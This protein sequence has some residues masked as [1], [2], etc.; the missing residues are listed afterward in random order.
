LNLDAIVEG[1][2]GGKTR[3]ISAAISL[4]EDGDPQAFELLKRLFPHGGRSHVVGI[5]GPPGAG[6]STLTDR[7]IGL[8]RA[9]GTR[10]GIVAVDPTSPYSGGAIL[11]DRVRMMRHF[12]DPDVFIRSMATRG[13]LG[14]I[15]RGTYDAVV[16]LEAA[17]FDYVLIETVGVGQ[18]EIDIVNTAH[19]SAV[20]LVPGMGDDV[21]AIKAGIL[22]IGDIFVINK[23]DRPGTN[24]LE[25]ELMMMLDLAPKGDGWRPPVIKTV[26]SQGEGIEDVARAILNHKAF[27][28]R[29]DQGR[30]N[31]IRRCR[32]RIRQLWKETA[33]E[34]LLPNLLS[35]DELQQA[36]EAMALRNAEPYSLIERLWA[37]LERNQRGH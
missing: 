8:A 23:A 28:E 11:G 19:T 4:V 9:R 17:G 26:A 35:D 20:I 36:A 21:Q 30:S 14:G 7:L 33:M 24:R 5:T 25:T 29:D 15:S 12:A 31:E 16:I 22:E 34:K 27:L 18:D 3:P 13:V 6:K 2:L 10:V 32:F 1:V 37:G